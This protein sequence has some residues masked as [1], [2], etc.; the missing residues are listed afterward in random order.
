LSLNA[1][2]FEMMK[3]SVAGFGHY[4]KNKNNNNTQAGACFI[5]YVPLASRHCR[6]F[7]IQSPAVSYR[8]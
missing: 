7:E 5:N 4:A 8:R 2:Q 3:N 1:Y 6:G